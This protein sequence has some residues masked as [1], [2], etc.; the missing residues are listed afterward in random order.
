MIES[1]ENQAETVGT[2]VWR[3]EPYDFADFH[4]TSNWDAT[5]ITTREPSSKNLGSAEWWSK[6]FNPE[7]QHAADRRFFLAIVGFCLVAYFLLAAWVVIFSPEQA[8]AREQMNQL[9]SVTNAALMASLAY[10]FS[11]KK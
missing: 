1:I 6:P 11:T 8:Q 9:H 10:F 5:D 7:E 3:S 2:E 4:E